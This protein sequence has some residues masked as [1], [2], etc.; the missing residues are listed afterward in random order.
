M[1]NLFFFKTQAVQKCTKQKI[2]VPTHT[3]AHP[4]SLPTN[5]TPSGERGLLEIERRPGTH[6][7]KTTK[8]SYYTLKV[9]IEYFS[10]SNVY[11]NCNI[12]PSTR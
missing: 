3:Y 1:E 9:C 6:T 2:K 5:P 4:Q 12:V 10:L 11:K 8:E 7:F